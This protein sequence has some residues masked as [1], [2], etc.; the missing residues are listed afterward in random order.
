MQVDIGEL[1]HAFAKTSRIMVSHVNCSVNSRRR[2]NRNRRA[3]R[4][5]TGGRGIGDVKLAG[6]QGCA[7]NCGRL[8]APK[9]TLD[10][11]SKVIWSASNFKVTVVWKGVS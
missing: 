6:I 1:N 3:I 11:E 5:A 10:S 9:A 2:H 4:D 7:V 8:V